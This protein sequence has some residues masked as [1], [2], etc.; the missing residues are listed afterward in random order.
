MNSSKIPN[1]FKQQPFEAYWIEGRFLL[2]HALG[3]IQVN[4]FGSRGQSASN[5]PKTREDICVLIQ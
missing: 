5:K 3:I 1:R 2:L 4:H